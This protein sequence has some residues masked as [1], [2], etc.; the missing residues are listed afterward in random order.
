MFIH[1]T[2]VKVQQTPPH[3]LPLL[4]S[5]YQPLAWDCKCSAFWQAKQAH[6]VAS[7]QAN[8]SHV[9]VLVKLA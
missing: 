9:S 5:V 7:Q 2:N 3:I 1:K 8:Y 6:L 4:T